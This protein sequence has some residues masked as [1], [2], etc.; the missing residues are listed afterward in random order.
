MDLKSLSKPISIIAKKS[1]NCGISLSFDPEIYINS[2]TVLY[3]VPLNFS[4]STFSDINSDST[5]SYD[6][7]EYNKKVRLGP[8]VLREEYR[9]PNHTFLPRINFK[10]GRAAPIEPEPLIKL[11]SL[12]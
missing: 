3:S 5:S 2:D 4:D 8:L 11:E 10:I 7:F 1:R 6:Q 12:N 9:R